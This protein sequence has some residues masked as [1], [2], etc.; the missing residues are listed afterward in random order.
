[1]K[2]NNTIIYNY[3]GLKA[4]FYKVIKNIN[5]QKNAVDPITLSELIQV[6]N[7]ESN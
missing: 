7:G 4:W 3:L 2:K 5:Q 6:L 1:M